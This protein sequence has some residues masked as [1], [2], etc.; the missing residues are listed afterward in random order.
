[1]MAS[2]YLTLDIGAV[3]RGYATG[4]SVGKLCELGQSLEREAIRGGVG[5]GGSMHGEGSD[6]GRR[7]RPFCRNQVERCPS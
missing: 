6:S 4:W 7:W 2:H 3:R 1:L 5:E